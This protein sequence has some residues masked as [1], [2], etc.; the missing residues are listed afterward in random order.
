MS[1]GAGEPAT[2]TRRD[3]APYIPRVVI[4]WLREAPEARWRELDGTLAFVDLSGFTAMSERLAQKGKAGAEELTEVLNATF[5][6]LLDVAY[7]NGGGLLKFG[8]DALLLFFSGDEHARRAARAAFDMRRTLR[9]IGRPRTSAGVVT[10]RMH[11]GLNSGVF[12][13]FLVGHSH[14]ELLLCGP[15]VTQTVAMEAGSD[16]G[17]ILLSPA[18][19]KA[20]PSRSVGDEKAGGRLL[21]ANVPVSTAGLQPLPDVDGLPLEHCV[22]L[23]V[24][25]YVGD[26]PIEPEHRRATVAFI[27]FEGTDALLAEHGPART[28]EALEELIGTVQAAADE[29]RVSFLETDIDQDGGRIVLV[30]GAPETA[31]DDEERMLRTVRAIADADVALPLHIGVNRGRVF[32]GEVGAPFRRTYTIMGDTAALAARLMSKA[33]AGSVLATAGILERS[34][35][36][37]ETEELEPFR[38]KGKQA[39]VVAHDIRAV[40]EERDGAP[41][42]TTAFVGRERE[43]AVL[44]AALAPVRMGFGSLVELIG[45]AGMGKSRLVEELLAQC[46]DMRTVAAACGEYEV[47]TPYYPFR[48]L[49]LSLLD[50]SLDGDP[51]TVAERLRATV[52]PIAEELVPWI[53]LLGMPLDVEIES[54]PEVD[55]LQPAFRRARLHGVVEMLLAK[56]LPSPSVL[57]IEDVHWMD[58]PSSDLLRHLG[59]QV[60]SKPWLGCATRRPGAGGFVAGEGVP[61]VAALTIHLEPLSAEAAK[62]LIGATQANGMPEDEMAAIAE[63][64]GGNPLFLQE[65]VSSSHQDVEADLPESVEAVVATRIDKLAPAD[66]TLLRFAAVMGSSFSGE[67]VAHVLAAEDPSASPDSEAW[68]RIAEFVERDPY[69]PGGFRFRHALFRDAAYEGLGFRRRRELHASVGSAYEVLYDDQLAEHAELLALHFFHAGH[70][71]KAYD[72]SLLAGKRAQEKY[73]NVEAAAF[74]RQALAAARQLPDVDKATVASVWEALGDVCELAGRYDEAA[75]AYRQARRL[76]E[77][78]GGEQPTLLHKEGLIRERSSRYPA[79]LRW[80]RRA[81]AAAERLEKAG[82]P[83]R[84]T[85]EIRLAYAGVRFRQGEFADCIEWCNQVVEEAGPTVDLEAL[86]HAYYLLHLAYTS[87]G[88]PD[89]VAFRGL[90]LPIYE[91]LGDLLGQANVLNNLGIDAYYEGRWEE[92]LDLY[93]RSQAARDRIGDVVGAATIAN[94][95]GE[96]KSDQGQYEAAAEL[97]S[98]ANDV[99]TRA[100]SLFLATLAR[101]NLGRLAARTGQFDEAGELL[102]QA[103]ASF[104]EM[105]AGSFVLETKARLAEYAVLAGDPGAGLPLADETLRGVE[106]SGTGGV[107]R[108]M[109]HR[110]R[111]YA[112]AQ[113]GDLDAAEAA[114]ESSTRI[115]RAGDEPYELAL[116]LDALVRLAGRRGADGSGAS[117][118]RE[119]I[120]ERLGVVARPYVPLP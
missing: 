1:A 15:E 109:L 97:F 53:P 79:A 57:V 87:I 9:E 61:P 105:K 58:E 28:A 94:N 112:L 110:V 103:L 7:E 100:G 85:L 56:L 93:G 92:A 48:T 10:L 78:V 86:A 62:A 2:A 96:I 83:S 40:A 80:Y 52:E 47:S 6:R 42:A 33:Q 66:R 84:I 4:E 30:A 99:C 34:R 120:F 68:D 74:Y 21:K 104:E 32:T 82:Q 115:A 65:L 43:L 107:V 46:V 63:R 38:V 95:I 45:D 3:L 11:V 119:S 49:L 102:R 50:V 23:A 89:R 116:S 18:T 41:Q 24:R 98:E 35:T 55:D 51:R 12:R 31:G 44:G 13:F 73:A 81:L 90:A 36:R 88:S 8:G 64:S 26:A 29:R 39:P 117:D 37:F 118:E 22:P 113:S 54:T 111:G 16:A 69:T 71:Q 60:T 14:R 19:A 20:L 101:S 77:T 25:D 5:A 108:A 70:H 91:D 17:E 59:G 76:A 75:A 27:R 67:L 106:E 114:V 72:Y